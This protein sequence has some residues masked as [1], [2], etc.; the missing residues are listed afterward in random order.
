[1]T[2]TIA[3]IIEMTADA[4]GLTADDLCGVGRTR[5]IAWARQEAMYVCREVTDSSF[6][7]IGKAFNR[8]HSTVQHA[9]R[10]VSSRMADPETRQRVE[11][12]AQLALTT[13]P[14]FVERSLTITGITKLRLIARE[15][16]ALAQIYGQTGCEAQFTAIAEQLGA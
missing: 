15:G 1:M 5:Q 12:I 13:T 2:A 10:Q 8:D 6:P 9:H 7:S 16:A 4:H 11:R 3:Q 14:N